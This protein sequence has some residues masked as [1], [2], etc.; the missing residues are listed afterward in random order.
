MWYGTP[1]RSSP[2]SWVRLCK[3]AKHSNKT[4]AKKR[5]RAAHLGVQ[6]ELDSRSPAQPSLAQW[7][8]RNITHPTSTQSS[9]RVS[10]PANKHTHTS[11]TSHT[12]NTRKRHRSNTDTIPITTREQQQGAS[13]APSPSAR[14]SRKRTAPPQS[15]TQGLVASGA[16]SPHDRQTKTHTTSV[17]GP[18]SPT[19]SRPQQEP[20]ISTQ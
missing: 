13:G 20:H 18:L 1:L 19:S 4:I 6:Q 9:P 16:S 17:T 12:E 14:P 3:L 7:R 5:K 2:K 10:A 11:H 8:H 15:A